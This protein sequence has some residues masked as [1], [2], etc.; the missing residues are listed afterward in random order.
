MDDVDAALTPDRCSHQYSYAGS[1]VFILRS[2][3]NLTVSSS[4]ETPGCVASLIRYSGFA[5]LLTMRK[6]TFI[7]NRIGS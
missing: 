3:S 4:A 5:S 6:R 1:G 7:N 2:Q